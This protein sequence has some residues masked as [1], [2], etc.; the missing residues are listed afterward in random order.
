M[1]Q[2][3]LIADG[4]S[5]WFQV[6][7]DEVYISANGS[8]GG[9]TLTLEKQV[10]G[11]TYPVNA[12]AGAPVTIA[13]DSDEVYGTGGGAIIRLTLTGATGPTLDWGMNA[14]QIRRIT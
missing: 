4:S 11:T 9:G 5:N 14:P 6:T 8:L 2:G 7:N 1:A 13:I 3:K 12:I 10:N